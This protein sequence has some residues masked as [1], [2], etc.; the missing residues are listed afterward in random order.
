MPMEPR[1]G[2][3]LG[4]GTTR[5]GVVTSALAAITIALALDAAPALALDP[6][7]DVRD[8]IVH[9][10][11][12]EEGLP[13]RLVWAV[14]QSA[15]GYLW[16]GTQDGVARFD[17]KTF[18]LIDAPDAFEER[19]IRSLAQTPDGVLWIAPTRA[20]LVQYHDGGLTRLWDFWRDTWKAMGAR[21]LFVDSRGTLWLTASGGIAS[22]GGDGQL[23]SVKAPTVY[24]GV[25]RRMIVED[26]EGRIWYSAADGVWRVDGD[27]AKLAIPIEGPRGLC[28][29]RQGTI[30]IGVDGRG[31]LRQGKGQIETVPL[32][33]VT[34]SET[35]EVNDIRLDRDDNLWIGTSSGL[36]RVQGGDRAEAVP[37]LRDVPV[38]ELVEGQDGS[39]WLATRSGLFQVKD[40]PFRTFSAGP[41]MQDVTS[42]VEARDGS[43]LFLSRQAPFLQRVA[44]G[45]HIVEQGAMPRG[46][47]C[48]AQD[49]SGRLWLGAED[50]L[51][52][53][54]E[55]RWQRVE[56]GPAG[57]LTALL[58]GPSG[59]L[60]AGSEQG[61][62]YRLDRGRNGTVER[63]ANLGRWIETFLLTRDGA[64]MVATREGLARWHD[65]KTEEIPLGTSYASRYV[66]SLTEDAQGTLWIGT[67]AGLVRYRQGA[68]RA[69][70]TRDGLP[71]AVVNAIV[72]DERGTLW[73]G[74]SKGIFSVSARG[75]DD[76]AAGRVPALECVLFS[77]QDGIQAGQASNGAGLRARD[78]GLWFATTQGVAMIPPGRQRLPSAP[79]TVLIERVVADDVS[80]NPRRLARVPPGDRRL[81][82]SFTAL[83]RDAP[84][85]T[86]FRYRLDGFD[87]DWREAGRQREATYTRLKAGRYT[88]RV[89]AADRS[90]AWSKGEAEA[91]L[92]LDPFWYERTGFY[93]VL[94][95]TSGAL[96]LASYRWRVRLHEARQQEL[97]S[98]VDERTRDLLR[99]IAEHKRTEEQ[100]AAS[101]RE[102]ADERAALGR[103]IDERLRQGRETRR[104]R[105]IL[106]ATDTLIDCNDPEVFFRRAV[107]LAREKLEIERCAIYLLDPTL[108]SLLGTYGTDDHGR[109]TNEGGERLPIQELPGLV[110][111]RGERWLIRDSQSMRR[112]G[113]SL[114]GVGAGW[115]AFTFIR[116]GNEPI[117]VLTNDAA[118]SQSAPAEILQEALALY[119]SLVGHMVKRMRIEVERERLI[120]EL[121]SKNAELERFTYSV[122]HDLK[123]PLTTIRGF[124]GFIEKTALAGDFDLLREDIQRIDRAGEKMQ[125]LLDD[126]LELSRVGRIVGA[127][128]VT[129]FE[130]IVREALEMVA[131]QITKRQVE[132]KVA[133]N[134]PPVYGDRARLVEVV[135]NL[136]DN[137]VKFMGTQTA[138]TI[139]IGCDERSGRRA[140]FV[141]DNG[142]GVDPKHHGHVF[143]LF[144]KLDSKSEGT[145]VGL[146]LVKRIV[147]VH[148]GK[149][150]LE[151]QGLG[152]GATVYFTLADRTAPERAREGT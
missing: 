103:E 8:Y 23:R 94:L 124:L 7:K 35:L 128:T 19:S 64:L 98:K 86:R 56:P 134:L 27:E 51:Y 152:C 111:G 87:R 6:A 38:Q 40:P 55:R 48:L 59:E 114:D 123:S 2:R 109:T 4:R 113:E 34:P 3:K 21:Q 91:Q 25:N 90:G 41:H 17:G 52:S 110:E 146:A 67:R 57:P 116:S 53:L 101:Y 39:L 18:T 30:W 83:S 88:F 70:D 31:L 45:R 144:R 26:R 66:R 129:S 42:L 44:N 130:G 145:G 49:L 74:C 115:V 93:L 22:V 142:I 82:F 81:S 108:T 105:A 126:L 95:M 127:Q 141:R 138:P 150:W 143:D 106:E 9:S 132:V 97:T 85:R 72:S 117:G 137:A 118:I 54:S 60:W 136:V 112:E 122:S 29:D 20:D 84:E 37:A 32:P 62:V 43:V 14:T 68:S 80:Y 65:G 140:F 24:V 79:P 5:R 61:A 10:W 139:E 69:F 119:C 147:E 120:A 46:A 15:E 33:G 12:D 13:H 135:Q 11:T 148:G 58:F 78:G 76:Y 121:E 102:L 28:I 107:E 73:I 16:L 131:G 75:V 133:P 96:L 1:G 47:R 104:L 149:M 125:R 100:L 50:G 99:E 151:S 92:K 77:R 71:D 89:Q 36:F 63:V